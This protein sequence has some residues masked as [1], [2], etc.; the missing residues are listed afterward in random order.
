[1]LNAEQARPV[2][3]GAAE[4]MHAVIK[5][6]PYH[7]LRNVRHGL[8]VPATT[9]YSPI[10]P[11]G[12]AQRGGKKV[13]L[14]TRAAQVGSGPALSVSSQPHR[15]QRVIERRPLTKTPGG[16]TWARARLPAQAQQG[17]TEPESCLCQKKAAAGHP[18]ARTGSVTKSALHAGHASSGSPSRAAGRFCDR[19]PR[20]KLA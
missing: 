7:S 20:S 4:R 2:D 12:S 8:S 5:T 3:E 16:P 13:R 9:R 10:Q 17:S 18:V 14:W 1:M 11:A 19:N 15:P 6:V